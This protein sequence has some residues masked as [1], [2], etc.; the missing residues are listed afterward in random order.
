MAADRG[1]EMKGKEIVLG[2]TGSIAAYKAAEL[3]RAL[4]KK[5]A[6]V[7][8]VL[9]RSAQHFVGALTFQTLSGR[10]VIRDLFEPALEP[11]SASRLE[12]VTLAEEADLLLVAPATANIIGKFAGGIADDF[13]STFFLSARCPV[14]IAPAMDHQMLAHPCYQANV[15]RLEALGV[16]FVGPEQGELASGQ[17]GKGRLAEI[18]QILAAAERIWGQKRD[19]QGKTVLISAG[20]TR[21]FLDPIRFLSNPSSGRM[22]YALAASARAR[23]AR[24]IL[25]SGP[26]TL[27][28]PFGVKMELVQSAEEMRNAMLT[29]LEEA[30]IIIKAAAVADYRPVRCSLSKIKKGP[31]RLTLELER[32]PDILQEIGSRKGKRLVVGFAAETEDLVENAKR[33]LR[34][35]NLDMIVANEIDQPEGGFG[36]EANQVK[37]IDREGRVEEL[38]LLSKAELAE[39]I[40][41][42]IGER[43]KGDL[44]APVRRKG[45]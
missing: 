28:A 18:S 6:K 7:T 32:T 29:H 42:R 27:P 2:V 8:C 35:K 5:G 4:V 34:R 24:V 12:H 37:L 44:P 1:G 15:K 26:T 43:L 33:K 36:Q 19:L 40:L 10:P 41:N 20:P 9:T 22:G 39:I 45:G 14:L 3:L 21:E 25:V 30:D 16:H 23:G 13:L 11:T 38:P 31:G 17:V